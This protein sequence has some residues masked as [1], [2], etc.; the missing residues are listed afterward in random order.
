MNSPTT[1]P[2]IVDKYGVGQS[3]MVGSGS[4]SLNASYDRN[5]SSG[6]GG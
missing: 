3:H 2:S 1:A 4:H 6:S 5:A